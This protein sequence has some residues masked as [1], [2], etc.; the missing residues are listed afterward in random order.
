MKSEALFDVEGQGVVVTGGASGI[1]LGYVEALARNGARVTMIDID[2]RQIDAE[3]TRL[4]ADGLD[5]VGALADVTDHDALDRAID[6]AAARHGLSAVFANAGI[7]PG[8]GYLGAWAGDVR[9]R[10]PEGALENYADDRWNRVID[11][12]LNGVFATVRAASRHM[13]PQGAG[14]IV[15]TTSVL[16]T[17]VEPA[18][19]AAYMATKAATRH[20]TA[21]VALELAAYGITV[22]AIAPG[23][24]VTNIGGGHTKDP[25]FQEGMA[26]VIPMHRV[27]TPSDLAGLALFLVSPASRYITG[28][29]IKI[30]GGWTLGLAD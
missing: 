10:N 29:E 14:S 26:K 21:S 3:L 22:N 25:A 27:G 17:M 6:G 30:D 4:N 7:D 18:I 9:P 24:I 12:N 19:G 2:E 16:A 11:I 1:G 20:L 28:Q 23:M 8:P 5:V 13:K 15:I